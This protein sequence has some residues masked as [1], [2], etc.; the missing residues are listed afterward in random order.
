MLGALGGGWVD[1]FGWNLGVDLHQDGDIGW[2]IAVA[3]SG[4]FS[5]LEHGGRQMLG[6]NN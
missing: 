2:F 5:G 4:L 1:G 6:P 3:L